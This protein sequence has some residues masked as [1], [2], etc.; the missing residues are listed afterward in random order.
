MDSSSQGASWSTLASTLVMVWATAMPP[1]LPSSRFRAKERPPRHLW[2]LGVVVTDQF[3]DGASGPIKALVGGAW[4]GQLAKTE[5]DFKQGP[6][7]GCAHQLGITAG[8]SFVVETLA[9]FRKGCIA[10]QKLANFLADEKALELAL[11]G[12]AIFSRF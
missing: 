7:H 9:M 10:V 2:L 12:A 8:I 5:G 11:H 4:L 1:R 6:P 3:G